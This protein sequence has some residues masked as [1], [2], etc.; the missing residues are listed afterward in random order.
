MQV[1]FLLTENCNLNCSMC[2]RGRQQGINMDIE[3]LKD[4]LG[5]N[6]FFDHDVVITGGEP[7]I[8]SKYQD[9]VELMCSKAKTVTVTSNGTLDLHLDALVHHDNL[10]FQ[11]S[12]DGDKKEHNII[13]GEGAFESTWRTLEKLDQLHMKYVVASVVSRKNKDEIFKLIPKLETLRYMRF[14][15]ISYEMPFGSAEGI[16]DI[17]G[18]D[19]WNDFVDRL[20]E[21]VKFRLKIQKIFPF[22]LYDKRKDE[23][24]KLA[25]SR[26]RSL[27]CGSGS[28]KIYVYPDFNV[29]P[30]TC[31]TDFCVGNLAA[32]TLPEILEG[33]ENRR[34]SEYVL[35]NESECQTCEYKTFCNGGCVGMSYHY[36]GELGMGDKRCPKLK[37]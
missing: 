11:I 27:N 18:A 34:F 9:I 16:T 26:K 25:A 19:E 3:Q 15:R 36:F 4:I 31:L 8:H 24:E 13:R 35:K 32:K 20:L 7:S 1:Y 17:M 23:L 6:D 28:S 30:C 12:L 22:D 2:I 10:Y 14:W 29:Y 21:V 5:K 37:K 33:A